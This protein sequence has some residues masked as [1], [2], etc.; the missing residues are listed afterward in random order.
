VTIIFVF[1]VFRTLLFIF[2]LGKGKLLSQAS[3]VLISRFFKHFLIS[4]TFFQEI[5]LAGAE[6][7]VNVFQMRYL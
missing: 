6:I 7:T 4:V 2:L 1:Y 5:N 3:D